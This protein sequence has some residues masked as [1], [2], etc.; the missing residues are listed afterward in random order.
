MREKVLYWATLVAASFCVPL[1]IVTVLLVN[2][3]RDIQAKMS[4]KQE[5]INLAR[6]IVP[7]NKKL[8]QA[9]YE[10]S[11]E[12]D[13]KKIQQLLVSQGFTLPEKKA[14]PENNKK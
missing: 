4:V 10:A 12:K 14:E 7:L 1:L 13:D 3:N 5:R 6:S 9:L 2:G 8:S 11:L